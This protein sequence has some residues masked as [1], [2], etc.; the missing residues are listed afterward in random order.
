MSK[1]RGERKHRPH[2]VPQHLLSL[3]ENSEPKWFMPDKPTT[4]RPCLFL[5]LYGGE[6]RCAEAATQHGMYAVVL[7]MAHSDKNDILSPGVQADIWKALASGCVSAV[8][9][10]ILC[11][12]WSLARRAPPGS[13][14]PSAV[15]GNGRDLYGLPNLSMRDAQKV[16]DG[17]CMY[18]HATKVIQ[19]C[20]KNQVPGYLENPATSRIWHTRGLRELRSKRGAFI[21]KTNMCQ[22][23][24]QW[25]KPTSFMLWGIPPQSVTLLRCHRT[26]Q[27]CSATGKR[28]LQLTGTSKGGF[29][30]RQAQ[31]YPEK[32]AASLIA[33]LYSAAEQRT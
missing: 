21:V 30:T 4:K 9:I 31:V 15:R 6:G 7:D 19:Y 26:Q 13:S 23:G 20:V 29:L 24:V 1:E 12:T 32:L 18:R 5:S 16:K 27:R 28:H 17:N 8:G 3:F 2:R 33:Q 10:D 14:F 25:M 11:S 22:Y